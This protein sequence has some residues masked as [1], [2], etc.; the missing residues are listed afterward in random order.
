MAVFPFLI[1]AFYSPAPPVPQTDATDGVVAASKWMMCGPFDNEGSGV[2]TRH[3]PEKGLRK[4]RKSEPWSELDKEYKRFGGSKAGW[5]QVPAQVITFFGNTSGYGPFASGHINLANVEYLWDA[6]EGWWSNTAVYLYR[7]VESSRNQELEFFVGSDDGVKLWF[8]GE[9][10]LRKPEVRGLNPFDD[11]VKLELKQG[12]NHLLVKIPNAGGAWAFEMRPFVSP[13]QE[14]VDEAIQSGIDWLLG[15]QLIDGSWQ[16]YQDSYRNGQT[17][18]CAYTLIKMGLPADHP[19]VLRAFAFLQ[20]RP[21][22][23]TYSLGCQLLAV[24]AANNPAYQ[25][26]IEEMVGDLISWQLRSGGWAYPSGIADMSITQYAALGL[27]AA[28]KR[29][30]R[31]SPKI[32]NRMIDGVMDFKTREESVTVS[33]KK[34]KSI[35]FSYRAGN[36]QSPRG[37]MSAAGVATLQL[38]KQVLGKSMKPDMVVPVNRLIAKG[39]NW[40]AANF[41]VDANPRMNGNHYY[42]LYGLERAGAFLD[43]EFFGAHEWYPHGAWY[44]LA[45]QKM[46]DGNGVKLPI[47]SGHGSWSGETD[48]CFALLFLRRATRRV[49]TGPVAKEDTGLFKS[50]PAVGGVDFRLT[51]VG[52]LTLWVDSIDDESEITTVEYWKRRLDGG[53]WKLIGEVSSRNISEFREIWPMRHH[54]QGHGWWQ[55][56]AI[57]VDAVG[58]TLESGTID[59]EVKTGVDEAYLAYADDAFDNL[60]ARAAPEVVVSSG[61]SPNALV[62]NKVSTSWV[63]DQ[64]DGSPEFTISLKRA[65]KV[66]RILFTPARNRSMMQANNPRPGLLE[67]I[68]NDGDVPLMVEV[69]PAFDHKTA[70]EFDKPQFV[71]KLSVILHQPIGGELGRARIGFAEVEFQR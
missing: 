24:S 26:W 36:N 67:I 66:S 6:G 52:L 20:A 7:A 65:H 39:N 43:T 13:P 30:V 31:V 42:W 62:D 57:A 21:A 35:G 1:L 53:E 12:L 4:M 49:S 15:R 48:T 23:K 60:L 34:T 29:G 54:L 27:W 38:C 40:L 41:R 50:D 44:I 14:L 45:D 2:D 51:N 18:L 63:C 3:P 69:N 61:G 10:V 37:S 68:I 59:I 17:A 64:S 58:G 28:N 55:L 32:W 25:P 19:A 22:E 8:N 47:R 5:T 16:T 56:R 70:L 9:E 71:K 33:G 46:K 11:I